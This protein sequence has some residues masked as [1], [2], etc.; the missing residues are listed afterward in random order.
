MCFK[1]E[2]VDRT[3]TV[4]KKFRPTKTH[5]HA[6]TIEAC[7]KSSSNRKKNRNKGNNKGEDYAKAK[8]VYGREPEPKPHTRKKGNSCDGKRKSKAATMFVVVCCCCN[9]SSSFEYNLWPQGQKEGDREGERERSVAKA[10]YGRTEG[11]NCLGGKWKG[12]ST[13]QITT[14]AE[15][16]E[17]PVPGHK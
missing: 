3:D 8:V 15:A 16:E 13:R 4:K 17:A 2:A 7:K 10:A 5:A 14:T 12:K 1:K 6:K 9:S 11:W